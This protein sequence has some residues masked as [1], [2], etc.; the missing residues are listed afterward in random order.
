[1]K[2]NLF[3]CLLVFASDLSA[4][5]VFSSGGDTKIVAGHE[6]SWTIG[7][8]V[9]KTISGNKTII[10]QGF[11]Q[12]KLLITP[13][14]EIASS[15]IELKVYPNP[16]HSFILIQVNKLPQKMRYQLYDSNSQLLQTK[17]ISSEKT[18]VILKNY[19]EGVYFLKLFTNKNKPLQNFKIIKQ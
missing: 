16:T 13:I 15:N 9:S 17:P 7:E 18:E 10:T 19:S 2:K 4:Q 3:L 5:E 8:P 1:M 11:Q 14:S 6:L 12:S